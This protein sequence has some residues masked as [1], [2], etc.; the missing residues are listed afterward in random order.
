[1]MK[2]RRASPECVETGERGRR[3]YFAGNVKVE[4][5]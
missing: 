4:E 5:K 2:G 3:A 1:M